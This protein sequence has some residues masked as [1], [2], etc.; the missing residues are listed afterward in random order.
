MMELR[1]PRPLLGFVGVLARELL[2]SGAD[3]LL[4]RRHNVRTLV[5][6]YCYRPRVSG[7]GINPFTL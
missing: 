6:P 7:P 5:D 3:S 2:N 4:G 1:L